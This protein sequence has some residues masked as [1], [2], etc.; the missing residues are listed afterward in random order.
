[1]VHIPCW[2][3]AKTGYIAYE[4]NFVSQSCG[5]TAAFG[6]GRWVAVLARATTCPKGPSIQCLMTLVLNTIRSMVFGTR[7]LIYVYIYILGTWTL[8]VANL[9][10]SQC[11][12][13][14]WAQGT[15]QG[16]MAF[17]LQTSGRRGDSS[18]PPKRHWYTYSIV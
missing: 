12:I 7:N 16:R 11:A 18:G 9:K 6:S 17:S 13:P 2:D 14:K 5:K 4:P 10:P 3:Y 8:W 1:M 15:Y